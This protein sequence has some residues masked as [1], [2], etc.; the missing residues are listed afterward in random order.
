M[1]E[2]EN[3]LEETKAVIEKIKSKW[4]Q[5][6]MDGTR[7]VWIVKPGAKSRGRGEAFMGCNSPKTVCGWFEYHTLHFFTF[8]LKSLMYFRLRY[9]VL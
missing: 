5:F 3:K 2:A 1:P 9:N 4:P 8:R 6:E 7:N